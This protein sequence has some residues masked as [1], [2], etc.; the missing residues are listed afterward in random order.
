MLAVGADE[1]AGVGVG[2][3]SAARDM[4]VVA[5]GRGGC[6]WRMEVVCSWCRR[7]C[8]L[9][10]RRRWLWPRKAGTGRQ[11]ARWKR[12]LS[13]GEGCVHRDRGGST[14]RGCLIR[15]GHG[16]EEWGWEGESEVVVE[17][18]VQTA[19]RALLL[20]PSCTTWQCDASE[21]WQARNGRRGDAV[22]KAVR[23]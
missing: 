8:R 17:R 16:M 15:C 2:E 23:S 21:D 18:R 10:G 22:A 14:V 12:R 13:G 7:E 6:Y 9:L 19:G 3:G 11:A 4:L 20:V 5:V 1:G